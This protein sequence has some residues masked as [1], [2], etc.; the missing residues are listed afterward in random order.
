MARYRKARP[1]STPVRTE[2]HWRQRNHN[3]TV[4]R[5]SPMTRARQAVLAILGFSSYD[6]YLQSP[7]WTTIRSCVLRRDKHICCG[8]GEKATQVH[9]SLYDMETLSGR[10]LTH[11]HSICRECHTHIEVKNDR[12]V[13]LQEANARLMLLI[14]RR[15]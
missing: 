7:L 1:K 10:D 2:R 9:H 13:S 6:S 5:N 14:R 4:Q 3:K 12:K 15:S 8:C 11:L